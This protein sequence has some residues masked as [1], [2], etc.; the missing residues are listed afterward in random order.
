MLERKAVVSQMFSWRTD[1]ARTPLATVVRKYFPLLPAIAAL[2]LLATLLEGAGIGLVIPLLALLFSNGAPDAVPGP[3]HSV[4]RFAVQ[5][6]PQMRTSLFAAAV[7]TLI[8][9][10]CIVQGANESLVE[11]I[12]GR[13]GRDVRDSL[14]ERLL[15]LDY[16]FFL[17]HE[18]SRLWHILSADSWHCVEAARWALALIPAVI[19]LAVFALLLAWLNFELF[20]F[21]L[22]GVLATQAILFIIERHQR[23][24]SLEVTATDYALWARMH[25][26]VH[27]MRVIR[28]F[29]QQDREQQLFEASTDRARRA[30]YSSR[31]LSAFG[32]PAIG[33]LLALIFLVTLLVGYRSGMSIPAITAFL[34]LLTRAQPHA[35]TITQARIGIASIRGPMAEV[36]WLL[37]QRAESPQQR[38]TATGIRLDRTISFSGVTYRYPN[39]G[40]G[41]DNVDLGISPGV[42]TALIGTSGSGKTTVVNL[43]A[44]LIEPQSGSIRLGDIEAGSTNPADWRSRIAIAGQDTE[45]TVGTV[46][47]NIAY[48]C[49]FCDISEIR[50]AAVAAGAADFIAALPSGY[51]TQVGDRGLNLSGGQ[52]QRIGLARALLRN[53]DLLILDEATNAVDAL[54][55]DR[56]MALLG[57]R[58]Y[59]RTAL[60][61]SHRQSTLSMCQ[62][63]IVIERGKVVEAGPLRQLA[64]Y[65]QMAGDGG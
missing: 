7:F 12:G 65:R 57:D 45:L 60:V 64:Y 11:S 22:V 42:A 28:L 2:G 9:L 30:V 10:K 6:D 19:G 62:N 13:I 25:S 63:G 17:K 21:V 49:S 59:F 5:F 56:I 16:P 15:T 36:E 8:L 61:I 4:T 38:P 1:R 32:K 33:A 34:L 47:E 51:G 14:A 27:A 54:L 50:E 46:A 40:E 18:A 31:R 53:P 41:L 3:L 37:C 55:E 35:Y 23:R 48:G 29:G 44:R 39:G 20:L 43:L 26:L 52:R 24:L 58:C